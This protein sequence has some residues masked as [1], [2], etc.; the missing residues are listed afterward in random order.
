MVRFCRSVD[1]WLFG[2]MQI[3]ECSYFSGPNARTT[4]RSD[5]S[6]NVFIEDVSLKN[7]TLMLN[8]ARPKILHNACEGVCS[9]LQLVTVL[10]GRSKRTPSLVLR[11][12]DETEGTCKTSQDLG[13]NSDN[14]SGGNPDTRQ[15]K[16][17][18]HIYSEPLIETTAAI[19]TMTMAGNSVKC[20]AVPFSCMPLKAL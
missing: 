7:D 5:D 1:S 11:S 17:Y 18:R 15:K 4:F 13:N 16:R 9:P 2:S 12:N 19:Q 14:P 20:Q 6:S 8:L 3:L 10:A